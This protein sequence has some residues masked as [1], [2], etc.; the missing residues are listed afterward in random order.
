MTKKTKTMR[1]WAIP[2]LIGTI[3]CDSARLPIY[4][5]RKPAQAQL[6]EYWSGKHP[7]GKKLIRVTI[8]YELPQQTKVEKKNKK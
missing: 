1:A 4:W 5:L 7:R 8:T 6:E 2:N 3:E